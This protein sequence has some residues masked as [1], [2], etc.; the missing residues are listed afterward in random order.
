MRPAQHCCHKRLLTATGSDEISDVL[1]MKREV[2]LLWFKL[3]VHYPE[4]DE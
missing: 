3:E 2:E 1:I 4:V